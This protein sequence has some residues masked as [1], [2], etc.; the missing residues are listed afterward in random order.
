MFSI[1]YPEDPRGLEVLTQ[2]VK[3]AAAAGIPQLLTFG[4]TEGGNAPVWG[5]RFKKLAPIAEDHGVLIVVP[6]LRR[7]KE[8]MNRRPVRGVFSKPSS[9]GCRRS[10]GGLAVH[11]G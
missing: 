5:E 4:H 3:Q 6:D 2:R 7:P 10:W 9:P 11:F 1:I 8:S